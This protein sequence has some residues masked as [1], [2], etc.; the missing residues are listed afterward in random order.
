MHAYSPTFRT[1][2][3]RRAVAPKLVQ[4]DIGLGEGALFGGES[5]PT[6]SRLVRP[7]SSHTL[8]SVPWEYSSAGVVPGRQ[9]VSLLN[10]AG[11]ITGVGMVR[12]AHMALSPSL[13]PSS[14]DA[15][16]SETHAD[17]LFSLFGARSRPHSSAAHEGP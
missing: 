9:I 1:L 6:I 8:V 17:R 7:A 14:V 4:R 13:V 12:S 5:T 2:A 15:C 3:V 10:C 16:A 11:K